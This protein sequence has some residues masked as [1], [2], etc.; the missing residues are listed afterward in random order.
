MYIVVAHKIWEEFD[1]YNEAEGYFY[2]LRYGGYQYV[3]MKKQ[4][5]A[6][7]YMRLKLFVR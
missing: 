6:D 4:I 3:E 7:R 5:A 2:S 1:N